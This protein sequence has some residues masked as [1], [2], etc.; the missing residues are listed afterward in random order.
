ML[1]DL[2]RKTTTAPPLKE[3]FNAHASTAHASTVS[4]KTPLKE[5]LKIFQSSTFTA[6]HT[7]LHSDV[8]SVSQLLSGSVSNSRDSFT[9]E[10][11]S[12]SSEQSSASKDFSESYSISSEQSSASKDFSEFCGSSDAELY[13]P[14]NS[15]AAKS[16]CVSFPQSPVNTLSSRAVPVYKL[17]YTKSCFESWP[18]D[19]M[20]TRIAMI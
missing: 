4:L 18:G 9:S 6:F 5:R 20:V 17:Q 15:R 2:P 16:S 12:I 13:S 19:D 10:C 1:I 14:E 3:Q 7:P 8:Q 11:Y